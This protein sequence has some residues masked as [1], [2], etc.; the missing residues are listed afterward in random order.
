MNE[1]TL[2][3]PVVYFGIF[4]K[5]IIRQEYN[6]L[7]Y[8]F[9]G[10]IETKQQLTKINVNTMT[11]Y[12]LGKYKVGMEVIGE[13]QEMGDDKL[14]ERIQKMGINEPLST[15]NAFHQFVL[16][17]LTLTDENRLELNRS[18]LDAAVNN[19]PEIYIAKAYRIAVAEEDVEIIDE[20]EKKL[21]EELEAK[22]ALADFV[23]VVKAEVPDLP[24]GTITTPDPSRIEEIVKA[25][26]N[27]NFTTGDAPGGVTDPVQRLLLLF[28]QDILPQEVR[29]LILNR[30]LPPTEIYKCK[31]I[32]SFMVRLKDILED[33][34]RMDDIYYCNK[35]LELPWITRFIDGVSQV[36]DRTQSDYFIRSLLQEKTHPNSI[37]LMTMDILEDMTPGDIDIFERMSSIVMMD[38]AGAKFIV[39]DPKMDNTGLNPFLLTRAEVTRLISL[40]LLSASETRTDYTDDRNYWGFM[41][42]KKRFAKIYEV[43]VNVSHDDEEDTKEA[44]SPNPGIPF[45]YDRYLL[46]TSAT[47]LLQLTDED[48]TDK[49]YIHEAGGIV[50]SLMGLKNPGHNFSSEVYDVKHF[51]KGK[52]LSLTPLKK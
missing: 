15:I 32:I 45:T 25:G 7:N 36:E 4:K 51:E 29:L 2:T 48:D 34:G 46:T 30:W 6:K 9:F 5:S 49:K 50:A 42:R 43:G 22:S 16:S 28:M 17:N 35:V 1:L 24:T 13:L 11:D 18:F 37:S 41:D 38:Y 39:S 8:L 12:K 31:C 21:L 40:G 20:K 19:R 3:F 14:E 33:I 27:S 52:R 44:N 10:T 26:A 47:E 23:E